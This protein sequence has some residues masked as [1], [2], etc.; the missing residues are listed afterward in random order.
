MSTS[1]STS[2][3]PARCDLNPRWE[4]KYER[5]NVTPYYTRLLPSGKGKRT[6]YTIPPEVFAQGVKYFSD[7][8]DP[9]WAS[10]AE[11]S[12]PGVEKAID[13]RLKQHLS[14]LT[15]AISAKG[16]DKVSVEL[17]GGDPEFYHPQNKPGLYRYILQKPSIKYEASSNS[18][19]I[20]PMLQ[21]VIGTDQGIFVKKEPVV[22]CSQ[23]MIT[24][25]YGSLRDSHITLTDH[26]PRGPKAT[27]QQLDDLID[28][29]IIQASTRR[30]CRGYWTVDS[31]P[32]RRT[33]TVH[34][35]SDQAPSFWLE[36]YP[37][38]SL[39]QLKD[40]FKRVYPCD[41][42][43]VST[44]LNAF[45]RSCVSMKADGPILQLSA[46]GRS[47]DDPS[48]SG[49]LNPSTI[50]EVLSGF[51]NHYSYSLNPRDLLME[52]DGLI[53]RLMAAKIRVC[54]RSDS[55]STMFKIPRDRLA[56][57]TQTVSLRSSSNGAASRR[58]LSEYHKDGKHRISFPELQ[59][60]SYPKEHIT[61]L[62]DELRGY[63]DGGREL[64]SSVSSNKD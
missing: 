13:Q 23:E 7:T 54:S 49:H 25:I 61:E 50:K 19:L 43:K 8:Y 41:K 33:E 52:S 24:Q 38:H 11:R 63:L 58:A 55:P 22:Y 6:V 48:T 18:L 15:D 60:L 59:I 2:L 36:Q 47:T 29:S 42:I 64:T 44:G 16:F 62:V 1:V 32:H 53:R 3:P 14:A 30:P 46:Q 28:K 40:A 56:A 17:A 27:R 35:S 39:N 57:E 4:R 31:V 51:A 20:N 26:T 37:E 9:N 21:S 34:I 45:N 10:Q 12:L 5:L